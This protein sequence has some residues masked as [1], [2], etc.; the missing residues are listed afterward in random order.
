MAAPR[1][2]ASGSLLC[3]DAIEDL[4][5]SDTVPP[6]LAAST[7]APGQEPPGPRADAVVVGAPSLHGHTVP[8]VVAVV[9][10]GRLAYLE[11]GADHILRRG[12]PS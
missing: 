1:P 7:A 6:L 3:A 10:P 12:T 2:E 8:P 4:A 5:A 9:C 11:P